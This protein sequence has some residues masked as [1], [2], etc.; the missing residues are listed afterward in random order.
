MLKPLLLFSLLVWAISSNAQ[1]KEITG[2]VTYNNERQ[3]GAIIK[4][5]GSRA[6][7]ISSDRGEFVITA[8]P[9]DTLITIK[10]DYIND[11][12][13]VSDQQYLI[14]KFRKKPLMLKEVNIY[15]MPITPASIY[16]ANKNEYKEIYWKGDKSHISS[17]KKA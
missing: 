16:E 3:S 7:T 17:L 15:G 11:T 10:D 12:L 1:V 8:K 4:N 9:G 13:L 14:I 2:L 6:Q 5:V